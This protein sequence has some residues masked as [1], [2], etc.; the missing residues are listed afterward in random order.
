M[1]RFDTIKK[2]LPE[3]RHIITVDT[4][5]FKKSIEKASDDLHIART[6]PDDHAFMLYTSG[7]TGK[8]KGIVHAHRAILHQ[9]MSARYVLDL[10]EED[11]FW[12]TADPGWITG[13]SYEILGNLALGVTTLVY[14]GR[15]DPKRW[16]ALIQEHKITVWYTAPTAIRM[17]MGAGLESVREYDHSS[18]RH[19]SSVGEP[20]NPGAIRWSMKAF[21]KP[22]HDTWFQTETGAIMIANFAMLD[23]RIG[24]MGKPLPGIVANIVDDEGRQVEDG[25]EGN[26]ALKPGW[27]AMMQTVWKRLSKYHSYFTNGW[28]MSGDRGMR[29]KDGYFWFIAR[30]DDV[31]KLPENR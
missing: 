20:L 5:D 31:I 12:C 1:L 3:L 16:Y 30:A 10:K 24:S 25:T 9:A 18:L 22:F 4:D 26:I 17:L 27:P 13:I 21:G 6:R 15:F 23:I 11:T 7:T 8:P 2:K 28:Y 19:L 29:D 14:S